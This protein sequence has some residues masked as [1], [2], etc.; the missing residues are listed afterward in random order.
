LKD[1]FGVSWQVFPKR[2]IEL[3]TSADKDVSAKA[4]EA[5]MQQMKIDIT[6]IETTVRG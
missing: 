1:R 2:P 4:F 5:I 6:S 3:T